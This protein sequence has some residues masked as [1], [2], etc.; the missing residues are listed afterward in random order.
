MSTNGNGP[1]NVSSALDQIIVIAILVGIVIVGKICWGYLVDA[2]LA[3][4]DL[5]RIN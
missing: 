2:F 4:I 1:Q 3:Y 5:L